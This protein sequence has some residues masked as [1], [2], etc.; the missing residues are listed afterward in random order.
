MRDQSGFTLIEAIVVIIIVAIVAVATGPLLFQASRSTN[1]QYEL[2]NMDNT[3][4][5]AIV[6]LTKDLRNVRS[7]GEISNAGASAITFT[8]VSGNSVSYALSG[9]TLQRN[10]YNLLPDVS[11]F[12][13]SYYD[14]SGAVTAVIANIRYIKFSLTIST[15]QNAYTQTF[16]DTIF[17][18][19]AG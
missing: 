9:T 14:A 17:L 7:S 3:A 4:R 2:A 6:R 18:R 11:S 1:T 12:A 15:P 19:N 16:G 10:G 13:L 5:V 8:D